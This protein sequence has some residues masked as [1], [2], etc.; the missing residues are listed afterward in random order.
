M[1]KVVILVLLISLQ[2]TTVFSQPSINISLIEIKLEKMTSNLINEESK[3][4]QSLSL[5]NSYVNVS[6]LNLKA[7]NITK[8]LT[9]TLDNTTILLLDLKTLKNHPKFD[10]LANYS[11]C[12]YLISRLSATD[13]DLRDLSKISIA[14]VANL[15]KLLRKRDEITSNYASDFKI[16]QKFLSKQKTV[17]NSI[18]Q[19]GITVN[20]FISYLRALK[21]SK[22]NLEI[23]KSFLNNALTKCPLLS[24][25]FETRGEI[26]ESKLLICEDELQG[27]FFF[28]NMLD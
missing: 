15:T 7:S 17:T 14:A 19:M 13:Y 8:K 24:E 25:S 11:T 23:L 16:L 5:C 28:F 10:S 4:A 6:S 2:F 27:E 12:D 9:N 21:I 1:K 26:I 18:R 20:S 3:V 22:I